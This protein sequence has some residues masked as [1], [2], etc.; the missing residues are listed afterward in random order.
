[1]IANFLDDFYDILF[2][3][4]QGMRKVGRQKTIWHGLLVYLVVNLIGTLSTASY[5]V[6]LLDLQE[7][8]QLPLPLEVTEGVLGMMPFME[9]LTKITLGPLYFL[10]AVAVLHL[11]ASLL[12]GEKNNYQGNEGREGIKGDQGNV[13]GLGAVLGYG[14]LPYVFLAPV[15][16]AARY[17][18]FDLIQFASLIFFFWA[19]ILKVVGIREVYQFSSS[20]A[21]LCYVLPAGVILAA[22]FLFALLAVIFFAPLMGQMVPL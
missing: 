21:L 8:Q 10:G 16:L 2:R 1:M 4:G 20:R 12:K 9:L 22:F 13:K 3:P 6:Q 15:S 18:A 5:Q 14:Y 7:L 11:A 17:V 19:L